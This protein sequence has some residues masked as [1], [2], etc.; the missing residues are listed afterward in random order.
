MQ[1]WIAMHLV[2]DTLDSE[3]FLCVLGSLVVRTTETE[4]KN[5][6]I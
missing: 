5:T 1:G 2:G 6:K 4:Q 3:R